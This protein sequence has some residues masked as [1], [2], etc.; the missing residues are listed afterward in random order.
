MNA[1][2]RLLIVCC[3]LVAPAVYADAPRQLGW[4]DLAVK[5]S[6]ADN[7]FARLTPAQLEALI[8]VAAARRRRERGIT[9]SSEEIS[10]E[11]AAIAQLKQ[12][13]IDI[14]GLLAKRE[15]VAEKQRAL[16][17]TVNQ[18]LNGALVRLPG[19]LLPL[20]FSG[21]Q[22]TEFLLVPW[23]GACI[24]TPPPPPNQIVHV[25]S[26]KPFEMKG[27]F[28]AVWVTGRMATSAGKRSLHLV[29]G[30]A[31]VEIGYSMRATL[32]EPYKQ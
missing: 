19:Y 21:Q 5:L 29:D 16:A 17:K 27:M 13:R 2:F 12:E 18:A 7:P 20:E 4:E 11:Q 22:V 10:N 30:S 6:A 25:K 32:V 24:H 15:E 9:L 28:D 31:D 1:S 23:I 3:A 8:D 14:D 26:A